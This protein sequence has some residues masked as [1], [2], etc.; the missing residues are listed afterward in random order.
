VSPSGPFQ[1]RA[2]PPYPSMCEQNTG[3]MSVIARSLGDKT[4]GCSHG[5]PVTHSLI[6]N[7]SANV[8]LKSQER[9]QG[10]IRARSLSRSD[11]KASGLTLHKVTVN[12]Q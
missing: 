2:L 4:C 9:E 1:G 10:R 5:L 6:E 3:N 8:Y 12:M 11:S 7:S